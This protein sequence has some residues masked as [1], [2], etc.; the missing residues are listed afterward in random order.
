LAAAGTEDY[1]APVRPQL[2][3]LSGPLRGRTVTYDDPSLEVGSA[4]AIDLQLADPAVMG[5]HGVIEF[6][7]AEC[8][9]HLRRLDGRVF[10]NGQE[11][12]EV[13]LQDGDLIEWGENGPK[14]RFHAYAPPGSVCKPVRRMLADARD[15]GRYS[16]GVAGARGFTRDL[17]TVATA[18]LKIGFPLFVLALGL[19]LAW[20][21]GWLG[22]RPSA[23]A[24]RA[25]EVEKAELEQLR[26][27]LQQQA[28]DLAHVHAANAVVANVQTRWSHGVCLVHGIVGLHS[29]GGDVVLGLDGAPA[30][31]EYTGSGF[32]C[33]DDGRVLTNRHVVTPWESTPDIQ[34]LVARGCVAEFV[35]LTATFPG[36]QP[37]DVPVD[38]IRRRADQ[39]DVAM[40]QLPASAVAGVP[41]LLLHEGPL[42]SLPDQRAIVV[43]YPTG[44]AALLAKADASVVTDL[45]NADADWT[46]VIATLARKDCIAPVITQ[47]IVGNVLP[48]KVEYDALTTHG[49]SGGPVFGSDDKVIAINF[50]IL[51]EFGGTNYGVPIR[52]GIELLA[53]K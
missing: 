29:P 8:A 26:A 3:H 4:P 9:F 53:A 5:R 49:G 45:Q 39:I 37:V 19:P 36:R 40:F 34:R 11:V 15:V 20:F 32:L 17:F 48:D 22:S 13:I 42:T 6:T 30:R 35:H 33:A 46:T 43:G 31:L 16:G 28:E 14:T 10:V 24:R 50:A 52:Y 41:V 25:G 23:A 2:L 21:G 44:L 7:E 38:S 12:E 18:R 51:R 47:G 27:E 1:G